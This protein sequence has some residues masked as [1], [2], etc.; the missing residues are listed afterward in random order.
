MTARPVRRRARPAAVAPVAVAALIGIDWA[1]DHHDFALQATD[2]PTIEAGQIPHT[3]AA[4]TTWLALLTQRFG[5]QPIGIA[6]ETSRGPLATVLLETPGVVLYPVNPRSLCRFREALSPNGAKDDAPDAQLLLQLL[7]HHRAQLPPWRPDD[8]TT[9]R[10]AALVEH[11]RTAVALRTQLLQQL[12]AA[13]KAYFP[14]ALTWAGTDLTSPMALA[15]L[16]RWPTLAAVQRARPTTLRQFYTQHGCRRSGVIGARLAEMQTATP[17]TRDAAL[18]TSSV[19]WVQLL[20]A[21][22]TTLQP[23]IARLEREIAA[24]FAAH[25]DAALFAS[26][27][28]AGAALAPRLLVAFGTDRQR[29]PS[30]EAMQTAAGVAPI[31]VRSG[32]HHAVYWRWATSTFLRQSFHEFAEQSVRD[33]AWAKAYY[34]QQRHRGKGH[35][36]AVRALAFKWIRILWRCWHDRVPYDDARYTRALAHRRSPLAATL[37]GATATANAA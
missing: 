15:F 35:H 20:L 24:D 2:T 29:F 11:R 10:L 25:P 23:E 30:A 1:D 34:H 9:R 13:L 21:Q 18:L 32:R 17:L 27:P 26:F 6:L 28:G 12:Q 19:S 16:R 14:Q 3:P 7:V 8:V 22:L 4:L 5:G 36:M 37:R 33:C 31:T